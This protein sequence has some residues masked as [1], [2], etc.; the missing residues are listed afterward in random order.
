MGWTVTSSV[1]S[2]LPSSLITGTNAVWIYT[3]VAQHPDEKSNARFNCT[4]LLNTLV[5]LRASIY[6]FSN[7]IGDQNNTT[8]SFTLPTNCNYLGTALPIRLL[9]FTAINKNST[10][11][12]NWKTDEEINLGHYEVQR[13]FNG[14]DFVSIGRINTLN[15]ASGV[16]NYSFTDAN[17]FTSGVTVIYY[18]L[19]SVDLDG[20]F[21]F[22]PVAK[23]NSTNGKI[24]FGVYPN[25]A[26]DFI[27]INAGEKGIAQIT[28]ITGRVLKKLSITTGQNLVDVSGIV[29]GIYFITV[30]GKG[31]VIKW[32]K[33]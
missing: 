29:P 4:G 7:W 27:F 6:T 8:A 30:A 19:K 31:D 1:S 11:E 21:S 5:N 33:Q 18:R 17:A 23:V 16:K 2:A 25:P 9:G 24:S 28:D 3:A 12:I 26:K 20:S 22:S 10:V 15:A 14:R 13:S 32:E